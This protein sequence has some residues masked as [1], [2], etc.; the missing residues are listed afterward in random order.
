LVNDFFFWW[1]VANT[2][3]S[4]EMRELSDWMFTR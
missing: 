4:F 3:S 1:Y 2:I